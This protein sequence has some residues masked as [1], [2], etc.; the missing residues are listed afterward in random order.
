MY[1]S[2]LDYC[3][4]KRWICMMYLFEWFD[5]RLWMFNLLYFYVY[6]MY[7]FDDNLKI[8]CNSRDI[9]FRFCNSKFMNRILERFRKYWKF[10]FLYC[11]FLKYFY[12]WKKVLIILYII[13]KFFYFLEIMKNLFWLLGCLGNRWLRFVVGVF[14]VWFWYLMERFIFGGRGILVVWVTEVARIK[15]FLC[16]LNFL[17]VIGLWM[18]YVEVEMFRFWL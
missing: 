2:V 3:Y 5:R 12:I 1:C 13:S 11:M 15:L 7:M 6:Y 14:I 8:I 10:K 9:M 17:R 18:W 16:F 4:L